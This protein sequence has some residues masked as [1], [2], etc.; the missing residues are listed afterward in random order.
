[1]L[2]A[3]NS[4]NSNII[5]KPLPLQEGLINVVIGFGLPIVGLYIFLY[6]RIYVY[7]KDILENIEEIFLP[8]LLNPPSIRQRIL[9]SKEDTREK[10]RKELEA[11][12]GGPWRQDY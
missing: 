10:M 12:C 3:S 7:Y 8:G 2:G 1:M 5:M 6:Y 9:A 4:N 11:K